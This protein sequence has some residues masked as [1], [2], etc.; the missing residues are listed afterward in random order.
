MAISDFAGST[1]TAYRR[2]RPDIPTGLVQQLQVALGLDAH[3]RVLDLGAG[4]GQ[5]TVP[6]AA[7]VGTVLALDPEPDMLGQLF[8]RVREQQIDNV[9]CLLGSDQ[10]LP[11]LA[12]LIGKS[13]LG[14]ITIGNALH[15]MDASTVFRSALPL[16]R[17][18]G[19][20]AVITPGRPLWLA[21]HEW[22]KALRQYLEPW[23]GPL[24]WNCG[25]D[26]ETLNERRE[27]LMASGFADTEVLHHRHRAMLDADFVL[28]HLYS[29]MSERQIP[30]DRRPE[31]ETGLKQTLARYGPELLE[32]D[33]VSVLV[34]RRS[35]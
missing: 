31:F 33:L 22:G 25:S 9:L 28:G 21:E 34:G 1:A 16:L 3:D 30:V 29:A 32:E 19:G 23:T 18:R 15:W 11:T 8:A 17:P 4:T 14:G 7:R 6:L 24:S 12:A 26:L 27:A 10:D 2:F 35:T 20:I 13:T 5:I